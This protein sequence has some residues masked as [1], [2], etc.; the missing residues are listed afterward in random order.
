MVLNLLVQFLFGNFSMDG[1][2]D[3]VEDEEPL[4]EVPEVHTA[5]FSV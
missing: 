5:Y 3:D 2:L 4:D 1:D